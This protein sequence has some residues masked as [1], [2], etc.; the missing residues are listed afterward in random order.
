[1]AKYVVE[2][3]ERSTTGKALR[4]F[5]EN[6]RDIS[7]TSLDEYEEQL[8]KAFGNMMQKERTGILVSRESVMKALKK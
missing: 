3:N 2:I 7:I 1:M 8:D 6:I 5:L 4:V